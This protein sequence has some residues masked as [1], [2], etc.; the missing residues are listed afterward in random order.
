MAKPDLYIC[1][2]AYHL[3]IALV[4]AMRAG[5]GQALWMSEQIPNAEAL[6]ASG[7]LEGV[8]SE[9]AVLRESRWPGV[10]TGP[11]GHF[12]NRRAYEKAE[13]GQKRLRRYPHQQRLE[14]GRAVSP[15]L[16]GTSYPL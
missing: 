1:H 9:V 13:A 12:R 6:A 10:V 5:G 3:L 8:F 7:K 16:P 11:L 15:G 4:R 14:R 2:T